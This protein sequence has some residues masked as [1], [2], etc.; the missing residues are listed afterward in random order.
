MKTDYCAWCLTFK[1][2]FP[3][4]TLIIDLGLKIVI[5][6]RPPKHQIRFRDGYQDTISLKLKKSKIIESPID[7][8][9]F[10]PT[11]ILHLAGLILLGSWFT[12]NVKR[13]VC[14]TSTHRW[15]DCSVKSSCRTSAFIGPFKHGILLT[16]RPSILKLRAILL[17]FSFHTSRSI[18]YP[19]Y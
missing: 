1:F 8:I 12:L 15:N 4:V 7:Y 5:R 17:G 10:W 18:Q 13:S 19:F 9:F 3:I 16:F 6:I 2:K 11:L 14:D